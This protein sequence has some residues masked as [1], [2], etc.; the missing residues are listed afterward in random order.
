MVGP[1]STLGLESV[2]HATRSAKPA[3]TVLR[4]APL[5]LKTLIF[6]LQQGSALVSALWTRSGWASMECALNAPHNVLPAS[7]DLTPA[8][9]ASQISI[10]TTSPVYQSVPQTT[11]L[12]TKDNV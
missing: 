4:T 1:S 2:K 12:T 7:Q 8:S 10:C 6:G 11:S 9:L 3:R 5:V